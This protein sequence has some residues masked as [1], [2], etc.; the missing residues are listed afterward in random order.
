M[1]SRSWRQAATAA[2]QQATSASAPP[3]SGACRSP[4]SCRASEPAS[5]LGPVQQVR[6]ACLARS[7]P[8][9]APHPCLPL[10][11][12][13]A[14][15]PAQALGLGGCRLGGTT[16]SP[17]LQQ[18]RRSRRV[19]LLPA[20]VCVWLRLQT[21]PCPW[22]R[23]QMCPTSN[24]R[25]ATWTRSCRRCCQT[26]GAGCCSGPATC[27]GGSQMPQTSGWGMSEQPPA[28]TRCGQAPRAWAACMGHKAQRC[29]QR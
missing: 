7:T 15:C 4:S 12:E 2:A 16:W 5:S 20:P 23:L 19:G 25:T 27:L 10:R 13:E 11:M 9:Q 21:R 28:S 8:G 1:Q 14:Q 17:R 26:W 6:A 18:Q 22:L 24:T 29:L 3:R